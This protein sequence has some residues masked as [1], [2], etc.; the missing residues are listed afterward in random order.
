MKISTPKG[1]GGSTKKKPLLPL[2][3]DAEEE[4]NASNSVSYLLKVKPADANSPTFKKYV[5]VLSGAEEVRTVLTWSQDHAQVLRGL[6]MADAA[7]IYALTSSLLTG[8]AKTIYTEHVEKACQARKNAAIDAAA[9]DVA[10]NAEKAK[11][12]ADYLRVRECTNAKK[13]VLAGVIP[14]KTVAMVKRYLRRECRKPADMKVRVYYQHL[15]R[16]NNDEMMQLP[17]FRPDQTMGE[18]ELIDILICATPKSW[19]REM[20]RQGFDPINKTL[21]EVV[22]FMERIEQAEDFDGQAVDHQQRSSK[23]SDSA[24]KSKTSSS[25]K[26][27]YCL[28]HGP[29][30]H[31]SDECKVLKAL[32]NDHKGSSGGN[33]KKGKF[34]NK[35]WSRKADDANKQ[36]KKD[37]A[38]FIKKQVADGVQKELSGS[39]GEKKRKASFDLNAFDEED[40][41]GFNY[42]DMDNLKIES[43]DD[44]VSV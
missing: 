17:P 27:K 6:A 14:N 31:P 18:D 32:A 43:D 2:V 19:G 1:N 39:K 9:D 5:R 41:K 11:P 44:S 40:L 20:D 8:S 42:Q 37:L 23:S 4:L 10:R 22:D 21:T 7:D 13:A 33:P 29:N 34:G 35:S 15:L 16:I 26:S 30:T 24:K 3:P 25:G 36:G 12:V 38:A 28:I